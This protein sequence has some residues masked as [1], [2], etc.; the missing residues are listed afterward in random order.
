MLA[1]ARHVGALRGEVWGEP[2][3]RP[4]RASSRTPAGRQR[5]SAA[6]GGSR[7]RYPSSRVGSA[8]KVWQRRIRDREP[9]VRSFLFSS[10]REI[11]QGMR[12]SSSASLCPPSTARIARSNY[13]VSKSDL[14]KG[15]RGDAEPAVEQRAEPS[16]LAPRPGRDD[17]GERP[18]GRAE[19]LAK[20]GGMWAHAASGGTGTD[21]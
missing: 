7:P 14:P 3:V 6:W 17:R 11:L 1:D 18:A 4:S 9:R 13:K 21:P 16:T 20:R 12:G 10:K 5:A 15:P 8:W 2:W 19:L